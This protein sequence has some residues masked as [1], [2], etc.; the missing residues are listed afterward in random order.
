MGL[1][2]EVQRYSPRFFADPD[3]DTSQA[4]RLTVAAPQSNTERSSVPIHRGVCR[5]DEQHSLGRCSGQRS[6]HGP[7]DRPAARR[8]GERLPDR[9]ARSSVSDRAGGQAIALEARAP[10]RR[11]RAHARAPMTIGLR[12][13]ALALLLSAR[14]ALNSSARSASALLSR[15]AVGRRRAPGAS[16]GSFEHGYRAAQRHR[17]RMVV[18]T[19]MPTTW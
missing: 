14:V 4:V 8:C 1:P 12:G 3:T 9:H 7:R 13:R 16:P 5:V 10:R 17:T 11:D 19:R 2:Y 15:S 6:A 18:T